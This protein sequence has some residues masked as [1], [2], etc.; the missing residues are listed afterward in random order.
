MYFANKRAA[1]AAESAAKTAAL[2]LNISQRAYVFPEAATWTDEGKAVNVFIRNSGVSPARNVTV[3]AQLTAFGGKYDVDSMVDEGRLP[4]SGSI[5]T[6]AAGSTVR[7]QNLFR[8][9]EGETAI[10]GIKSVLLA[11]TSTESSLTVIFS[12]TFIN[13]D[14]VS[15]ITQET[16]AS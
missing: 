3:Q 16:M 14:F 12:G 11:P 2:S 7:T 15:P 9:T 13:L 10:A 6:I 4:P 1:G 5:G 8:G